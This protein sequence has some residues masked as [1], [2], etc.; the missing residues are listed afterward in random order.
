MSEL[1]I[2]DEGFDKFTNHFTILFRLCGG[3][4]K[5]GSKLL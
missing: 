3:S 4:K 2:L 5:I 1:Q